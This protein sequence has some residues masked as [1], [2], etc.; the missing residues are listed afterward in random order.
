MGVIWALTKKVVRDGGEE[1]WE[2]RL[3]PAREGR[4]RTMKGRLGVGDE[5]FR[6]SGVVYPVVEREIQE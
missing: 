1:R 6:I 2:S 4:L 3:V 5:W